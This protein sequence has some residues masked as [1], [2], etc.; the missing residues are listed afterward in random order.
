MLSPRARRGTVFLLIAAALAVIIGIV[1]LP[2]GIEAPGPSWNTLGTST[3]TDKD[4]KKTEVPLITVTGGESY[5][6][7]GNLNLL[8]VN[9]FG[10]PSSKPTLFEVLASLFNPERTVLPLDVF[11]PPGQSQEEADK[12][13]KAQMV[14][15]QQEAIAAA[16]TKLGYDVTDLKVDKVLDGSPAQGRLEVGDIIV[17]VNGTPIASIAQL[18]EVL[19]VNGADK[20][21]KFV[22]L[23]DKVSFTTEITPVLSDPDSAGNQAPIIKVLGSSTYAFPF[24]VTIQL[25]DVGGPSAGLMFALGVYDKLT[26]DDLTGGRKIAGTGTIDASGIVGPIGGI[27]EKM[28]GARN[29]GAQYMFVPAENCDEAYGHVPSG[30]RIFKVATMTDALTDLAVIALP[31]SDSTRAAALDG[32]KT[33]TAPA[34]K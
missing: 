22:Y 15:S 10:N 16:F 18:R 32:L 5:P 24:K 27:K 12:E 14:D 34:S 21:A 31:D 9:L 6:T 4:G 20:P 29:A 23:R 28:Y 1:P 11:F 7:T 25:N 30:I 19:A 13:N 2:Y 26:P 17:S 8:T 3:V 33:C